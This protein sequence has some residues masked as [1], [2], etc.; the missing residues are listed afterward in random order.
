MMVAMTYLVLLRLNLRQLLLLQQFYH[1]NQVKK[2]TFLLD[3]SHYSGVQG[4]PRAASFKVH[5]GGK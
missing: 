3:L 1:I 2:K 4:K 5:K